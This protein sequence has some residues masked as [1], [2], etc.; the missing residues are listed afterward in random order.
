MTYSSVSPTNNL[1][2]RYLGLLSGVLLGYALLGKGFAYIGLPPLFAGEITLLFGLVVSLRTKCLL[3]SF[4]TFPS[5]VLA[6]TMCWVLAR[7]LPFVGVYGFDALRDSVV[8][9]YGVFAF[10]MISLLVEDDRRVIAIIQYYGIFA[11]SFVIAIPFVFLIQRFMADYIPGPLLS[12]QPNT[13]Q[14][15]F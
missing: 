7:T 14:P 13:D 10:I 11:N 1:N 5:L 2:D 3:A 6:A 12:R 15:H 4:T 8:I 9:I